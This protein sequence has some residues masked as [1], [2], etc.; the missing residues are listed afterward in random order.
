MSRS[1]LLA[2]C[3]MGM[4]LAVF[5]EKQG[6]LPRMPES[7]GGQMDEDVA[8]GK[9][10]SQTFDS[11]ENNADENTAANRAQ[12]CKKRE[13]LVSREKNLHYK[14]IERRTVEKRPLQKFP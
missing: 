7:N 2:M 4:A 12:K 5:A 14:D 6:R 8:E 9:A 1:I 10:A 13:K 3:L 11:V